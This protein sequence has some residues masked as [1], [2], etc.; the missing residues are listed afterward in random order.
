[1]VI[2]LLSLHTI[3]LHIILIN[4]MAFGINLLLFLLINKKGIQ[5]LILLPPQD[6]HS[7]E[8]VID[9]SIRYTGLLSSS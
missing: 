4:W 6:I 5:W 1:M 2:S 9:V 7:S 8:H 3:V